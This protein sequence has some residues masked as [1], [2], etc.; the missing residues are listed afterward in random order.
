MAGPDPWLTRRIG[1]A[2]IDRHD[3]PAG[4]GILPGRVLPG[5]H[6]VDHAAHARRFGRPGEIDALVKVV[7][8][9]ERQQLRMRRPTRIDWSAGTAD[10]VIGSLAKRKAAERGVLIVQAQA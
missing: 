3:R 8:L 6:E 4:I 2:D 7:L 1:W 5:G 9:D 10:P